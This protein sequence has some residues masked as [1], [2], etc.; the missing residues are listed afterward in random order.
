[1]QNLENFLSLNKNLL[2]GD[3]C[4][5]SQIKHIIE[6]MIQEIENDTNLNSQLSLL[7]ESSISP[8][9]KGTCTSIMSC[10]GGNIIPIKME[11]NIKIKMRKIRFFKNLRC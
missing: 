1:M 5:F 3:I 10:Y 7:N 4:E 2:L 11:M 6:K 8:R 9:K